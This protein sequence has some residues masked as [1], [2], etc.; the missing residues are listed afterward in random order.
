MSSQPDGP[1]IEKAVSHAEQQEKVNSEVATPPVVSRTD[2]DFKFTFSK[3]L[4]LL[5]ST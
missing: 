5:V 3:W 2:D 4:A 1:D